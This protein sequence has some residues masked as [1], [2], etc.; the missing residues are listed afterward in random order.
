MRVIR[1]FTGAY[2]HTW[3][4]PSRFLS[5]IMSREPVRWMDH[6]SH[7]TPQFETAIKHC[8]K[9]IRQL[10]TAALWKN[11]FGLMLIT[12]VVGFISYPV[13]MGS[14]TS[15]IPEVVVLLTSVFIVVTLINLIRTF[16][17]RIRFEFRYRKHYQDPKIWRGPELAPPPIAKR[18]M[19]IKRPAA[20]LAV[21][22]FIAVCALNMVVLATPYRPAIVNQE[23]V[24]TIQIVPLG[25]SW[26]MR[27][28]YPTGVSVGYA[29][30]EGKTISWVQIDYDAEYLVLDREIDFDTAM[31]NYL[32]AVANNVY[33]YIAQDW[34]ADATDASKFND[35]QTYYMTE[36]NTKMLETWFRAHFNETFEGDMKI[37]NIDVSFH[38]DNVQ[39]FVKWRDR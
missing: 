39:A 2:E 26:Q 3:V 16:W 31:D 12:G 5:A 19:K 22:F 35:V 4:S 14:L 6:T 10:F 7:V 36:E 30:M 24:E 9:Y 20:G 32:A 11:L 25:T 37:G 1:F 38:T 34:G 17:A 33:N 23:I 18:V 21:A 27:H 8:L 28:R 29:F 13:V 15:P